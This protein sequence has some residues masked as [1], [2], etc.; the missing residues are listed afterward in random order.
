MIINQM[1]I[2]SNVFYEDIEK[3]CDIYYMDAEGK[4]ELND[5]GPCTDGGVSALGG[6][7]GSRYLYKQ[8]KAGVADATPFF[9][10][11]F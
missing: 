3:R 11:A 8:G 6:E 5:V 4:I 9:S 2:L 1:K 7:E 10:A